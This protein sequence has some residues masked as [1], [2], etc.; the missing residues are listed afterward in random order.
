M[1][2]VSRDVKVARGEGYVAVEIPYKNTTVSMIIVM[3]ENFTTIPARYREL[4]LDAL[5]KLGNTSAKSTYL[6]MPKLEVSLRLDLKEL[7]M[8]LGVREVFMKG[9]ADLTRMADVA[10]GG[11]CVDKVIHAAK[12]RVHE[13]GTEAAAVTAITI[14]VSAPAYEEEV[15]I[16]KPF[17]YMLFDRGSNTILFIGH[18]VN[19]A[20]TT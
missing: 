12:I 11:I 7:L 15:R 14:A 20:I 13:K 16:N 2:V 9:F 1:E 3:P 4:V 18:V 8:E 17:I 19:P 10:R 5:S 6:I